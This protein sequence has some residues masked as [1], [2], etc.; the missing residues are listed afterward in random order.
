MNVTGGLLDWA[1]SQGLEW[2]RSPSGRGERWGCRLE[3]L[4][5]NPAEELDADKWVTRLVFRLADE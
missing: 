1:A 4:L 5:T 3:V 2:D